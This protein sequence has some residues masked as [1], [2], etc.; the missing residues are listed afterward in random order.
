MESLD[1]IDGRIYSLFCRS[2][3]NSTADL[4]GGKFKVTLNAGIKERDAISVL[5]T[6]SGSL[7][8]WR[9]NF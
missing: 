4:T 9:E 3:N 7:K 6:Y 2:I 8:K 5:I 1:E